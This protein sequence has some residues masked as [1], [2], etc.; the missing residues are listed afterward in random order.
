MKK[1]TAKDPRKN[2][3]L[4]LLKSKSGG[5]KVTQLMEDKQNYI[6]ECFSYECGRFKRIGPVRVK[7]VDVIEIMIAAKE[8]EL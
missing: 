7:K 5:S 3:I 2:F 8:A 6:G 4:D 1:I